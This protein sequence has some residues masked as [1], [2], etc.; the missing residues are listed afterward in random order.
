M[1]TAF[2][3]FVRDEVSHEQADNDRVLICLQLTG[4]GPHNLQCHI[5]AHVH[6]L[7]DSTSECKVESLEALT[8]Q[9]NKVDL[10]N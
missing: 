4:S 7:L 6:A 5:V 10:K 8:D 1:F 2:Q 9:L 3:K